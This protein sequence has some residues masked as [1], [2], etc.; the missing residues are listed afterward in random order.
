MPGWDKEERIALP[1][2]SHGPYRKEDFLLLWTWGLL[3][4]G[5]QLMTPLCFSLMNAIPPS[6]A[7]CEHTPEVSNNK[8]GDDEEEEMW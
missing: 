7:S 4:E 1:I 2:V 5:C 6:L 3:L 8:G